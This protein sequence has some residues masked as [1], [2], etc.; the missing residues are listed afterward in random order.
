MRGRKYEP[1]MEGVFYRKFLE[2][3]SQSFLL[4]EIFFTSS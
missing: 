4:C 3:N 2:K 1:L